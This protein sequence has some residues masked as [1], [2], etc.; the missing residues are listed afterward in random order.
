MTTTKYR[1]SIRIYVHAAPTTYHGKR[2]DQQEDEPIAES[3]EETA[4]ANGPKTKRRRKK[5]IV[6]ASKSKGDPKPGIML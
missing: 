6:E 2:L 4:K 1:T 5:S 3:L